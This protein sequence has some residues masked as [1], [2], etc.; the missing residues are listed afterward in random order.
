VTRALAAEELIDERG[1]FAEAAV[2]LLFMGFRVEPRALRPLWRREIRKVRKALSSASN[3]EGA[4]YTLARFLRD[5][6]RRGTTDTRLYRAARVFTDEDSIEQVTLGGFTIV[7]GM[8]Q[9]EGVSAGDL[10]RIADLAGLM[11]VLLALGFDLEELATLLSGL[12]LDEVEATLEALDAEALYQAVGIVAALRIRGFWS[13]ASDEEMLSVA[14]G[15]LVIG[16]EF[17]DLPTGALGALSE[18]PAA[19]SR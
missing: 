9:G 17:A 8:L 13:D 18:L 15:I 10:Q 6:A 7:A 1:T 14:L 4:G 12:S 5:R 16:R 2:G 11:P 3:P 19:V